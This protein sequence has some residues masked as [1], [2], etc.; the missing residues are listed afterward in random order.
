MRLE[1][2]KYL[3]DIQ[4]AAELLA[5]FTVGKSFRDYQRDPML[6]AAVEMTALKMS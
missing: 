3:F 4:S 2:K 6:R 5:K 1:V